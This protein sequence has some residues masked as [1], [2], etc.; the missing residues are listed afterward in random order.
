[1]SQ[2]IGQKLATARKR[3]DLTIEDIAHV[4]RIH[5]DTLRRLE[6]D[7][8]SSFANFTYAK[9]FLSM[10]SRYLGLDMSDYLKEFGPAGEGGAEEGE[11]RSK[12]ANRSRE[13]D[14]LAPGVDPERRHP[15]LILVTFLALVCGIP[16]MYFLGRM[17]GFE[18]ATASQAKN[19]SE[20]TASEPAATPPRSEP[21]PA[22]IPE[23]GE[24]PVSKSAPPAA[25][26]VSTQPVV[27]ETAIGTK[28][29]DGPVAAEPAA[30][31][32]DGPPSSPAGSNMEVRRPA[33]LI[34]DDDASAANSRP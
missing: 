23:R 15:I 8:Y 22:R 33:V 32:S 31:P 11:S 21:G 25:A 14:A 3:R 28:P 12:T 4:T 2:S 13:T 16:G 1:M 30:M 18:T 29:V 24:G 26:V 9:S 34:D 10:Y 7:D 17:H 5:W 20:T 19:P 27:R 6:A